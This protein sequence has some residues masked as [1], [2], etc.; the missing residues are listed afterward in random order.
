MRIPRGAVYRRSVVSLP[1]V[2]RRDQITVSVDGQPVL[3]Y[4]G[5]SV[6]AVLLAQGIRTFRH[7]AK[8]GEGRGIYCGIGICYD[9][10]VTVDGVA[11]LRACLTPVAA[12][13][14]IETRPS[15]G[16]QALTG[17]DGMAMPVDGDQAAL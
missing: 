3:A 17:S 13:C 4:A 10:L 9:C 14:A 2:E 11:N 5:E 12:G 15:V 7:T 1:P 16:W 8:M 6:A